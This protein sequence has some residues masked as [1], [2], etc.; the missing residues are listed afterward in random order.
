MALFNPKKYLDT[1]EQ[2]I[3]SEKQVS[4]SYHDDF[5]TVQQVI[6]KL[7]ASAIDITANYE[8][9]VKVGF[10]FASA[11]GQQGATLFHRVSKFY[12][13]YEYK[14]CQYQYEQCL[15]NKR[16]GVT[17]GTFFHF[18]KLAGIQLKKKKEEIVPLRETTKPENQVEIEKTLSEFPDSIFKQLPQY[19]QQV[20]Q[21][22]VNNKERDI[23]LLGSLTVI[24]A[25]LPNVYGIYDQFT[26]YPNLFLFITAPASSGKGRV[27]LCRRLVAPIHHQKRNQTN[28]QKV[29]YEVELAEY[30][31]LKKKDKTLEKPHKPLEKMLFIPANS[32]ATGTFQLLANNDG[33]GLIFETEGDTLAQ[34][35]K[36]EHG[37]YSD[38]FRKAFHHE[39]ISYYRRTDNEYV[40]IPC[41]KVSTLLTGTPDQVLAL[42]PDSENGLFSRFMFYRM[43]R[44]K[45]WRNVFAN[46]KAEGLDS[47]FD[48]LGQQFQP[49]FDTLTM[50]HQGIRIYLQK[51]HVRHFNDFFSRQYDKFLFL[52]KNGLE[53]SLFRL[54][55]ICY[56]IAMVL[57]AIRI[58]EN[59]TLTPSKECSS[60]DFNSALVITETLLE[61]T[62][63]VF[64]CLP[65]RKLVLP[66]QK[67]GKEIFLDQ[68]PIEFTTQAFK[69]I[70]D[71]LKISDKSAERYIKEFVEKGF[72]QRTHQGH[73]SNTLKKRH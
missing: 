11:F 71:T 9:W 61:H 57:S 68:L 37:N 44:Q 17:L 56:R 25:C 48:K 16:T 67:N 24:S 26:V 66:R 13:G 70:A 15:K 3:T 18:T 49:F 33:T 59:D 32:S 36:S 41:P 46:S 19:I 72:I 65:K 1:T 38:G 63:A 12:Q 40:D 64:L 14:K 50:Q 22:A 42:M 21:P 7:E 54:G 39:P 8:D 47:I 4:Q 20:L 35:F 51:E 45:K 31:E 29:Q 27:N 5:D 58:L 52:K 43:E 53:A 62:E 23:L 6:V 69:K 2:Q 30:Y 34:T 28:A 55:L 10:A 73:Y 60:Q